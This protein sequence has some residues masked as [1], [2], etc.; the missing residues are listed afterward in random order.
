VAAPG[1]GQQGL[2]TQD[3]VLP[4]QAAA[5]P[6]A[7]RARPLHDVEPEPLDADPVALLS[8]LDRNHVRLPVAD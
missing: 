5:A 1:D 8:D 7:A 4:D 6:A 2:V 3:P